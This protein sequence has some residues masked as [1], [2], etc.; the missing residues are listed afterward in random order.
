MKE[1]INTRNELGIPEFTAADVYLKTAEALPSD[2]NIVISEMD[3]LENKMRIAAESPSFADIDKVVA[4][5]SKVHCF[6]KVENARAQA[7]GK[8]VRYNLSND[9]DCSASAPTPAPTPT[10]TPA[11]KTPAKAQ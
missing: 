5:L 11:A 7:S 8:G 2:V 3:I 9:I 10:E 4:S 1:Q 6:K